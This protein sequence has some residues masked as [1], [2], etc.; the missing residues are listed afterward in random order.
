MDI[1]LETLKFIVPAF[2]A[3]VAGRYLKVF[4]RQKER[5]KETFDVLLEKLPVMGGIN[6]LRQHDMTNGLKTEN[7][8]D[9]HEFVEYGKRPDLIFNDKSLEDKKNNLV[10][11]IESF[12]RRLY[13]V[14]EKV[15]DDPYVVIRLPEE[16]TFANPDDWKMIGNELNRKANQIHKDYSILLKEARKKL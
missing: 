6:Y 16:Y 5:D 12:L 9:L 10:K 15:R 3:F 13:D 1:L 7:L 2:L 11:Q 8:E 14:T 4:D